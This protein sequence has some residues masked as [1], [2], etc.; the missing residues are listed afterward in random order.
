MPETYQENINNAIKSIQIADHMAYVTYPLVQEK[1]LLLKI[2]DEI[3]KSIINSVNAMLNYDILFKRIKPSPNNNYLEIFEK[4][5]SKNY[6]LT[7]EQVQKI[8]EI[9][10]T[11]KKSQKSVM[12]FVK[13]DKVVILQ[14]NLETDVLDIITIKKYI[15]LAKELIRNITKKIKKF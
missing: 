5:S 11:N 8:K 6:E 3:Y 10:Q 13:K 14:N 9:I 2:F 15:L 12:D 4:K 7:R 1:R